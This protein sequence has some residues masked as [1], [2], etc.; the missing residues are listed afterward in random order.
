MGRIREL[1][2]GHAT[3]LDVQMHCCSLALSRRTA[4]QAAEALGF[5]GT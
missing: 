4:G 5:F 1:V 2:D 3:L